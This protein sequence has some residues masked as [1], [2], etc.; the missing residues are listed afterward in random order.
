MTFDPEEP[1]G[2][3]S[4]PTEYANELYELIKKIDNEIGTN[5][6][7]TALFWHVIHI[8]DL[9]TEPKD[10]PSVDDFSDDRN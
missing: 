7:P 4:L 8:F 1:I 5:N 2:G 9:H 6:G 3:Y 10:K